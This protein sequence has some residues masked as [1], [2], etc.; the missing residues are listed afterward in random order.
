MILYVMLFAFYTITEMQYTTIIL[1][2][3]LI[4][5]YAFV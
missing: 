4:C 1:Y 2:E 5:K 3:L